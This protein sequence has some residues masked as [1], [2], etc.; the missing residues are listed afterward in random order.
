MTP[1]RILAASDAER[2]LWRLSFELTDLFGDWPWVI[3]GAQMVML[4]EI[5]RGLPSGRTTGDVD[6]IVDARV[7]VG[8]MRLAAGR[9]VNA[10]FEPSAEHAHRFVRGMDQVDL[11]APD[12]LGARVDLTTIPPQMTTEIPGGSR[13]LATRRLVAVE[14]LGIG[15]C[16]LPIP[17]LAGAIALKIR[18]YEARRAQ[19]DVEDLVRLLG[20]IVDVQ[21]VRV[22]LKLDERKR[23]GA[24]A[25]LRDDTSRA[26]SVA[27]DPDEARAAFARLI[28]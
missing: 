14:I 6:A 24:I 27:A 19:R 26:W 9:L 21:T 15:T 4:L 8:A 7:A 13:A 12:H 16:E 18:A 20:L 3:I 1:V 22:E 5:E 17:S 11:L 10:G 23:L 25:P 28:D 2:A